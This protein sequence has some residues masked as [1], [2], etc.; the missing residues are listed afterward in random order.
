MFAPAAS[1]AP[2]PTPERKNWR[3]PKS[4]SNYAAL[5][6]EAER[7]CMEALGFPMSIDRRPI[8]VGNGIARNGFIKDRVLT[9]WG[10]KQYGKGIWRRAGKAVQ[11]A[12]DKVAK[13]E[14]DQ[15]ARAIEHL[16]QVEVSRRR[17]TS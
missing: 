4:D 11:H 6:G 16:K 8:A 12:D 5:A 14:I 2:S 1:P 10:V 9:Q 3:L 13:G 15:V 7:E 17:R